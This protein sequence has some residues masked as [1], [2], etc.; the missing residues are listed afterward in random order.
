MK[1]SLIY[2]LKNGTCHSYETNSR[3]AA[4]IKWMY[5]MGRRGKNRVVDI[6]F[7]DHAGKFV[8]DFVKGV[9][10]TFQEKGTLLKKSSA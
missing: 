1:F 6:M 2:Q 8:S 9:E 4:I 3:K 5:L 10:V 7:L